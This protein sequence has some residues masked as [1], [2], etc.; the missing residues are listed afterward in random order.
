MTVESIKEAIAGLGAEE[1]TSLAAWL[2]EQDATEWDRQMEEDFSP[3]GAGMALLAEAESD[4]RAGRVKPM[5][6]F[7][8]EA[9]ANRKTP[10]S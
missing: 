7:M 2:L 3:G 4:M 5:D 8:A 10:R 1:K 9:K 6:E